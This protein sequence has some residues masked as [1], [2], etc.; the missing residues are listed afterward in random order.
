MKLSGS[1]KQNGNCSD[2]SRTSLF[3]SATIICTHCQQERQAPMIHG[4]N[5]PWRHRSEELHSAT[6]AFAQ[7]AD[8]ETLYPSSQLRRSPHPGRHLPGTRLFTVSSKHPAVCGHAREKYLNPSLGEPPGHGGRPQLTRPHIPAPTAKREWC[9]C[10]AVSVSTRSAGWGRPVIVDFLHR[11][12]NYDLQVSFVTLARGG[13]VLWRGST[14]ARQTL[15]LD[16][17]ILTIGI[18]GPKNRDFG[19]LMALWPGIESN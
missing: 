19:E 9:W 14:Y 2:G 18:F 10:R 17:A 5:V 1:W 4:G 7:H 13:G 16:P 6:L 8:K 15:P 11:Q 3:M 12:S